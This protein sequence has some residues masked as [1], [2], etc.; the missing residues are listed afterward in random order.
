MKTLRMPKSPQTV[1]D[2]KGN[3]QYPN[4]NGCLRQTWKVSAG[5]VSI[6]ILNR[7]YSLAATEIVLKAVSGS[8][9][10][11]RRLVRLMKGKRTNGIWSNHL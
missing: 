3:T 1:T 10:D 6:S 9:Q 5:P 8:D 2:G 7:I 4:K 11:H